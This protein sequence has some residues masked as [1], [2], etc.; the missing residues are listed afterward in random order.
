MYS[1]NK[2]NLRYADLVRNKRIIFVGPSDYLKG[3]GLGKF[4]DSF[5]L[6][7]YSNNMINLL[8][9]KVF[10]DYGSRC[11]ILYVNVQFE[12]DCFAVWNEKAWLQKGLKFVCR[13]MGTNIPN[14]IIK[15]ILQRRFLNY[16][17]ATDA[18][19]YPGVLMGV[20][21]VADLVQYPIKSLYITGIDGYDGAPKFYKVGNYSEYVK[22]YLPKNIQEYRDTKLKGQKCIHACSRDNNIILDLVKHDT[23]CT[24]DPDCLVLLTKAGNKK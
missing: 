6:V 10:L 15:N 18:I 4:I 21:L 22:G 5:D 1:I 3:K 13:K 23:R 14:T 12:R 8:D 20:S 16:T 2:D 24:L 19:E 11:D 9:E 17:P 7:I